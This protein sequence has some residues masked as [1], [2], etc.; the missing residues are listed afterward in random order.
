MVLTIG[1][2]EARQRHF[3]SALLM[4]SV[5]FKMVSTRSEKPIIIYIYIN[6]IPSLRTFPSVAFET[7]PIADE[8]I[9]IHFCSDRQRDSKAVRK[10]E[11]EK[12]NMQQ[13]VSR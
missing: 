12:T 10:Q 4:S 5:Q 2:L 7:V 8:N 6:Q 3:V 13:G 9:I 11:K 1:N